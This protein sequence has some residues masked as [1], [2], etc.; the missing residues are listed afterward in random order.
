ML[1]ECLCIIFC[2]HPR[3]PENVLFAEYEL[4]NVAA[5]R[6]GECLGLPITP[7]RTGIST[8]LQSL[9]LLYLHMIACEVHIQ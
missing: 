8:C 9:H 1:A 4:E 2:G 6:Q 7:V 3:V 5:Y